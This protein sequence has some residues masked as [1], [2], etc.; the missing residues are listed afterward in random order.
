MDYGAIAL[1]KIPNPN[2][3]SAHYVRQTPFKGSKREVRGKIIKKLTEKKRLTYADLVRHITNQGK[4]TS[5]NLRTIVNQLAHEG[6]LAIK[7]S[8]V[9]LAH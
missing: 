2:R 6:F 3:K 5:K 8:I 1:K 7:N 9:S 4:P